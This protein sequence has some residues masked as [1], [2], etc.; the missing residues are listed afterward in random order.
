MDIQRFRQFVERDFHLE[1]RSRRLED[2]RLRPQI[3]VSSIF[4]ALFYMGVLGLGSLLG[5]DQF[6]RTCKGKKLFGTPRPLVSDSTLWRSLTGFGLGLL[7]GM[8]EAVYAV[9][10]DMGIGRCE[11]AG[12]RLRIGMID[13]SCFGQF[14]ASCFAHIG[15]VCLMGGLEPIEGPGKEL[16]ASERLVDRLRKRLGR[17]FVDLLLLDGLYVAQGFLRKCLEE[18]QV[19]VLIK[20]Q[21]EGLNIIQ[22]AMGIFQHYPDYAQDVEHIKGTDSLRMRS[23]EVYAL[24]GFFLSGVDT[25]FKVAWVTEEDLRTGQRLQFWVLTS[26][27]SL[28]AEDMRELAHWRWDIENNGFKS[29]NDLVHTKHLYAHDAHAAQAVLLIL[30]IAGNL[31]QLF[32]R[33]ISL[34]EVQARL[35]KV[36]PTRRFLQGV[37]KESLDALPLPDT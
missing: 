15:S 23:F 9:G 5:L 1:A 34:E 20:T 8:L 3:G 12:R 29:L 27:E 26:L 37:L 17:R 35:G 14:R 2:E 24:K 10:R 18:C 36:K 19:D 32:L 30:L 33:H 25:P 13:G 31:L 21:E 4:Q 7:H 11:V 28:T 16:P 22:D 6:L